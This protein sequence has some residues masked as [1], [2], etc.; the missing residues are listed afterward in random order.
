MSGERGSKGGGRAFING[1]LLGA[2]IGALIGFWRA[3]RSGRET[4]DQLLDQ[5]E[6]LRRKI[7][8]DSVQ[9][10]LEAGKSA[11]RELNRR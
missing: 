9:D 6:T 1:A 11:A 5:A 4:R 3:P 2:I 10:S 8:G 7:E